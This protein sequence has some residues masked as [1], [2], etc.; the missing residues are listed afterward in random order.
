LK[1]G[2]AEDARKVRVG[3]TLTATKRS[4]EAKAEDAL[5]ILEKR[6]REDEKGAAAWGGGGGGGGGFLRGGL[7]RM[8]KG[9]RQDV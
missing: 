3:K 8:R 2:R 5:R 1:S 7:R 9:R 4:L 6:H